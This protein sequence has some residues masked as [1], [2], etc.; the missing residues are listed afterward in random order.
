MVKQTLLHRRAYRH[1][2][3]PAKRGCWDCRSAPK[4]ATL[5]ILPT[6]CPVAFRQRPAEEYSRIVGPIARIGHCVRPTHDT[7]ELSLVTRS[8][9]VPIYR[10]EATLPELLRQLSELYERSSHPFEMV[11]VVDGSPDN[12]YAV[13]KLHLGQMPFSSQLISL[14]RNFG[15]FAAIRAGMTH[16]KGEFVAVLAADLQQP[17]SS[18]SQFFS[19]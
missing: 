18:V 3:I 16:A 10:N 1:R 19:A 14:S 11:F 9:V 8:V 12:S 13:L 15:S 6:N 5:A 17:I 4:S 7:P 2:R